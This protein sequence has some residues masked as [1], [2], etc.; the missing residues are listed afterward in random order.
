MGVIVGVRFGAG[1]THR[2]VDPPVGVNLGVSV[3]VVIPASIVALGDG[4]VKTLIGGR[5]VDG[6]A[7]AG[8][9]GGVLHATSMVTTKMV[10]NLYLFIDI[11]LTVFKD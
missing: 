9:T 11:I 6:V 3:S 2:N 10:K 5:V 8:L 7:V 4:G 1:V